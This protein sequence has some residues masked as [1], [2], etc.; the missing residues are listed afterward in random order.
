MNRA[1][2]S[3]P[4]PRTLRDTGWAVLLVPVVL[5]VITIACRPRKRQSPRSLA[6]LAYLNS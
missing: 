6:V 1:L 5:L 2:T 4:L 3:L